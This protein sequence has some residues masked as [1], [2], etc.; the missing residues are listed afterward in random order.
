MVLL[1]AV[2][3]PP[4]SSDGNTALCSQRC[5]RPGHRASDVTAA[6]RRIFDPKRPLPTARGRQ[7]GKAD[8]VRRALGT[9]SENR[10][11]AV[12]NKRRGRRTRGPTALDP[13]RGWSHRNARLSDQSCRHSWTRS[14]TIAEIAVVDV[15]LH[16]LYPPRGSRRAAGNDSPFQSQQRPLPLF[17][18][19]GGRRVA[20]K[21]INVSTV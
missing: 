2:S 20:R 18:V 4:S 13:A 10:F 17:S 11:F 15:R 19:S 8:R 7:A 21:R 12:L 1:A 5:S 14:C 16:H 3:P 6:K 9:C